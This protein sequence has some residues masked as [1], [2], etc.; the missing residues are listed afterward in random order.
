MTETVMVLAGAMTDI[1]CSFHTGISVSCFVEV[2]EGE[3]V[4]LEGDKRIGKPTGSIPSL[5]A[6][7]V[8]GQ[9]G[10]DGHN[11]V[12]PS[13]SS[14]ARP[15]DADV[16]ARARVGL[17]RTCRRGGATRSHDSASPGD[18]TR[19]NDSTGANDAARR[20]DSTGAN[21]ARPSDS[22]GANDATRSNNS[23]R[24]RDAA[25]PSVCAALA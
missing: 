23:A 5:I 21:S 13:E 15:T 14:D 1:I 6:L 10:L 16:V 4:E 20:S 18:A 3:P 25:G 22:T 2:V 9:R 17:L 19:R 8:H 12:G 24:S 11:A 7:V